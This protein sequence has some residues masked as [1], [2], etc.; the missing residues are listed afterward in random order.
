MLIMQIFKVT[1]AQMTGCQAHQDTF[2]GL[3]I[4]AIP[5]MLNQRQTAGTGNSQT[6]HGLTAQIFC[7]CLGQTQATGITAGKRCR[8]GAFELHF[9]RRA[10]T[11]QQ[12]PQD[13]HA[14]ITQLR[15]IHSELMTGIDG[16]NGLQL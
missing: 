1:K 12:L 8:P 2:T 14:P 6:V 3:H 11:R 10:V 7:N 13:V 15:G 16:G 4:F 9:P 5:G